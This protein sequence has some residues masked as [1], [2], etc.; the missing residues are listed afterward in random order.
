M[1]LNDPLKMARVGDGRM[2]YYRW[3]KWAGGGH[4]WGREHPELAQDSRLTLQHH[5]EKKILKVFFCV[6]L[7]FLIL[8]GMPHRNKKKNKTGNG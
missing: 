6:L 3:V 7:S 5:R 8:W 2:A 1:W 4:G